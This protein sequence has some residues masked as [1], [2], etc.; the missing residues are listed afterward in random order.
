MKH[1][2]FLIFEHFF[3]SVALLR[4]AKQGISYSISFSLIIIDS[5]VILREF[6]V[7]TDLTKTQILSIYKLPKLVIINKDKNLRFAALQIVIPSLK[8]FNDSQEF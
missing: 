3:L 6:L 7:I 8:D 5:K 2:S 4:K 1:L